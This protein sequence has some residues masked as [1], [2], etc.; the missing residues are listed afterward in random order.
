M[1]RQRCSSDQ[2]DGASVARTDILHAIEAL[3]GHLATLPGGCGTAIPA[4][5]RLRALSQVLYCIER[6]DLLQT[7]ELVAAT[8][9]FQR[10]QHVVEAGNA[11]SV[12]MGCALVAHKFLS[13]MPFDNS[14][15]A[16]DLLHTDAGALNALEVRVLAAIEFRAAVG[17]E[18]IG[19]MTGRLL[20]FG[21]MEAEH[22]AKTA[23]ATP[24]SAVGRPSSTRVV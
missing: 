17:E 19:K 5:P 3:L 23:A 15:W 14:S 20:S 1:V 24:A 10:C 13:D 16:S 7:A 9:L 2:H 22:M 8:V 4:L 6:F 21:R 18:E 12:F 11:E